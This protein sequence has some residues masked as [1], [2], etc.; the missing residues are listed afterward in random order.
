MKKSLILLCF[1][2]NLALVTAWAQTASENKAAR[3]ETKSAQKA[4][5]NPDNKAAMK[6]VKTEKI[7]TSRNPDGT[8]KKAEK[9]ATK[10]ERNADGTF[11]SKTDKTVKTETAKVEKEVKAVPADYKAAVDKSQKGPGGE[12]VY[13]GP[14]GGKYYITKAGNKRYLSSK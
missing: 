5:D 12:T 13:A 7:T 8:F 10:V 9:T 14:R 2:F 4:A 3:K 11:K 1:L 6:E